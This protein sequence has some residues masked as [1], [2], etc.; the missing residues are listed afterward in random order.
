MRGAAALPGPRL[1]TLPAGLLPAHL[2]SHLLPMRGALQAYTRIREAGEV[3]EQARLARDASASRQQELEAQLADVHARL[4][5]VRQVGEEGHRGGE[6]HH[7]S[8]RA[9]GVKCIRDQ[10]QGTGLCS[11]GP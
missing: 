7:M 3:A 11:S 1:A 6:G 5:T 9:A 10:G 4:A 2:T 8:S